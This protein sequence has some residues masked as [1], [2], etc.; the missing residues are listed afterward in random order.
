MN[1]CVLM[2]AFT[3]RFDTRGAE[4]ILDRMRVDRVK[5]NV[6][7]YTTLMNAYAKRGDVEG[8]EGVLTRMRHDAA[9]P[10]V[11]TYST[12]MNVYARSGL[13]Q[14]AEGVLDRMVA[15]GMVPN[16]VTFTTLMAAYSRA[17]DPEGAELVLKRMDQA[18]V[19]PNVLTF[20]TLLSATSRLGVRQGSGSIDARRARR[21]LQVYDIMRRSSVS[22]LKPDEATYTVLL[23]CLLNFP[24][25]LAQEVY[26]LVLDDWRRWVPLRNRS[27]RNYSSFIALLSLMGDYK[28]MATVFREAQ[29]AFDKNK[30]SARDYAKVEAVYRDNGG[31]M[32]GDVG[33][34]E[35]RGFK[36][37]DAY[38]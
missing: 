25:T 17:A 38:N 32:I 29:T 3:R 10:N 33:D 21:V 8:A 5:P 24:R 20:N 18:G 6:Q 14:G 15:A 11:H 31:Y 22:D 27:H 7:V 34:D 1:Y 36:E 12:L 35:G 2:D 4:R 19:K 9:E 13:T 30:M 23:T 26:K 28:E 37:F 16:V